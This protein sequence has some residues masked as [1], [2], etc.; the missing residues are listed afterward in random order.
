MWACPGSRACTKHLLKVNQG[1]PTR[2]RPLAATAPLPAAPEKLIGALMPASQKVGLNLMVIP[3]RQSLGGGAEHA[4]CLFVR[5]RYSGPNAV[6]NQ[7]PRGSGPDVYARWWCSS[8]SAMRQRHKGVACVMRLPVWPQ[9]AHTLTAFALFLSCT[10]WVSLFFSSRV[11]NDYLPE[12]LGEMLCC[13]FAA[14]SGGV[15]IPLDAARCREDTSDIDDSQFPPVP[16]FLL[17][18]SPATLLPAPD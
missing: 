3:V 15:W 10:P 8:V 7:T 16:A 9:L 13:R 2:S 6:S 1:C 4:Q 14:H 17:P 5:N 11:F 18:C 12:I